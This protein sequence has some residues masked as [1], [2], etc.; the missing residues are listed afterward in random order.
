MAKLSHRPGH[1]SVWRRALVLLAGL[2]AMLLLALYGWYVAERIVR[3]WCF[4]C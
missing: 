2:A 1:P 4:G 3:A